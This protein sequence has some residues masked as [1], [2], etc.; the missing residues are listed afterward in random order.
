M[1]VFWTSRRPTHREHERAAAEEH[2]AAGGGAGR[3]DRARASR[4]RGPAPRG[5]GR[6]RTARSRSRARGPSRSACS[7][8][9]T[10]ADHC[11]PTS[12]VRPSATMIETIARISGMVAATHGAEDEQ[13]DDQRGRK[14][15]A[16][17]ALLEVALG[18][19]L[20]VAVDRVLAGDVHRESVLAVGVLDARR[21]GRRRVSSSSGR[22]LDR[23]EHRVAVLRDEAL[24]LV[25]R[26]DERDGAASSRARR[27]QPLDLRPEGRSRARSGS[28]FRMTT[29]SV[30]S[31][32]P[33]LRLCSISRSAFIDSGLFVTIALA[34]QAAAE[35][36]RDEDERATIAAIQAPIVRHGWAAA[37]RARRSVMR[38]L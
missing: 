13:E 20:E 18:E 25:R 23:D 31:S 8:R 32:S 29:S 11:W 19:L 38:P 15:V 37:A 26:D 27:R 28:S 2:G 4:G 7:R 16:Q 12:A 33:G 1:I 34:R 9:R 5:S 22:Q 14:P 6:R 10:R 24:A 36:H 21:S 17:L 3:G 30:V 35:Q